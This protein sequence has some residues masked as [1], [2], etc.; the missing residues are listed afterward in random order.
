M[1]NDI[2]SWTAAG[3]W[4]T[5]PAGTETSEETTPA[6]YA[7]IGDFGMT[8]EQAYI[9]AGREY[10]A[11]VQYSYTQGIGGPRIP[12]QQMPTYPMAPV[13]LPPAP[14]APPA[15]I[16]PTAPAGATTEEFPPI[17]PLI[18]GAGAGIAALSG[19]FLTIGALKTM[20]RQLGP[21]ILKGLIGLAAFKEFTDMLG[22]GASDDTPIRIKERGKPKR[23]SIG[24]NPRVRTLARVARHTKRLLKRHEK[25]I[26]EFLPKKTATYGQ[27]PSRMLS[28]AEKKLLREGS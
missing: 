21:K 12:A 17:I 23:Y 6:E 28:A 22:F 3:G 24:S 5:L 2:L 27:A 4:G 20:L 7:R 18:V 25:V 1:A 16:V 15:A 26:R 10:E 9:A 19:R 8:E 11:P 14:G 13:P